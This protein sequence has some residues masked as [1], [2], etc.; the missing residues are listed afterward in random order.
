M[1]FND[2]LLNEPAARAVAWALLQFVW[3][4]ALIGIVVALGLAAL[5]RSAPDVRYVVAAVGLALMLTVPVVTAVQTWQSGRPSEPDTP[6]LVTGAVSVERTTAPQTGSASREAESRAAPLAAA[7]D[8]PRPFD[9]TPWQPALLI[10]WLCGVLVLTLRLL[11]GW[12]WVQRMK[13]EGTA[14]ARQHWVD[15]ASRLCRYLHIRRD[16]RLLESTRVDVPT[17]I[18]WLKPVVLLPATA[19]SGLAPSQLEAILAHELAHVRRHDYLVNLLQTLVET[20]LFYHP[21]VWWLSHRI[22]VE[23]E[24]C[25]DDLAVSL[26][27]DPYAYAQALADLE[28]RRGTSGRLVLAVN[29]GPLLAR[30]RR[31]LGAP[32]HAGACPAWVA[33]TAA[34]LLVATIVAGV[35]AQDL[36]QDPPLEPVGSRMALAGQ[37]TVAPVPPAPPTPP[38][39]P[40]LDALDRALAD[41][42]PAFADLAPALAALGPALA[43]IEPALASL[44]P[45]LASLQPALAQID[46]HLFDDIA[47]ELEAR[48]HEIAAEAAAAQAEVLAH[49]PEIER[50]MEAARGTLAAQTASM[51]AALEMAERAAEQGAAIASAEH[52]E[53]LASAAAALAGAAMSLE[54]QRDDAEHSMRWSNGKERLEIDVRGRVEFTDDDSD[55]KSL[56]PGGR[57]RIKDGGWFG[58]RTV[59]FTAD[60]SGAITRRFWSGRSEQPF[61]PEGRKWL[62]EALPRIIR[63]TGLGAEARVARIYGAKGIDGVLAEI[64]LIEGSWGKRVYFTELL[65]IAKIDGPSAARI[66]SQ[67]G[68]EIDSDFELATLLIGSTD[69]LMV[70]DGSRRAFFDAARTIESDFE[71]RRV[72]SSVLKSGAPA[73]EAVA[74]MLDASAAIGSDFEAA[75]LLVDVAKAGRLDDRTRASFFRALATVDSDFEARRV[76]SALARTGPDAATTTAMLEAATALGSDF[77]AAS[78]LLDVA[79]ATAIEGE[80]RAPFFKA[81]EGIESS[82]ERGRVLKAVAARPG[83]SPETVLAVLQAAR[84]MNSSHETSQVLLAVAERHPLSGA[85]RDAY[86]DAAERLGDFEQGRAMSALVKGERARR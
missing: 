68:R 32:S 42:G 62:A 48:A 26:C 18:G 81:A 61:E 35:L 30:V 44:A 3:Q 54:A 50:A 47:R 17:V 14:P 19:M 49:G 2:W 52:E 72:F 86:I 65:K 12:V 75:S 80:I 51:A 45:A 82:F 31:L 76:L 66:L 21:A 55:V 1:T 56:S 77:E 85:A 43:S 67:A 8:A 13:A 11:T 46:E 27:G 34:A 22:R 83:A 10:V 24:H 71:M 57:L 74:M 4:G 64:G 60:G 63:Q 7:A 59:E 28:E 29:G 5:R 20:L 33:G 39:P 84:G 25:C 58:G 53:A 79:N 70:D 40:Q 16:V 37:P 41:L 23:R 9:W 78:F 15:I 38:A 73:P 69:R 6:I 36:A